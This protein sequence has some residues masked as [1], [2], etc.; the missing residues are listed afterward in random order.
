MFEQSEKE[1]DTELKEVA[2]EFKKITSKDMSKYMRPPIGVYSEESL[3]VTD[4]LG[5][6]TIFWSMDYNDWET[7]NQPTK[8]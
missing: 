1:I 8:E 2:E 3:Y 6:K 7:V 4:K 5:Y